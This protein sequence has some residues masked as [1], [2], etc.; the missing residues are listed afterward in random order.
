MIPVD[1]RAS[2]WLAGYPGGGEAFHELLGNTGDVRPHWRPMLEELDRLGAAQVRHRHDF[3]ARQIREDGITYNVYADAKGAERPWQ[4]DLLPHIVPADEWAP[5]AAGIAQRAAV[6]DAMLA[7]L[8]GPQQLLRDGLLPPELV[9]GHDN[10]L[11]PC[12]GLVPPGGRFLHVYAADLARAP[13]GRWWV[14]ADRTQAPS[15]AGYALE[16]RQIVSRAFPELLRAVKVQPLGGFFD[17][18]LATL[19][20]DAPV[21]EGETPLA[22]L[23]TAGRY[24]ETYFEHVFLARHLGVPLVEGQDLTVRGATLYLKTLGGLRRVHAVLRRLDD[25]F[26]D[27]LELRGDSALGVAGLLDVARAGRVLIANALGSGVLDSPGLPGFLPAICERLRGEPLRLPSVATWWCGEA[28]ACEA[29][30]DQ[31]DRLVVKAAFPSQRFEPVFGPDL[32]AA[33]REALRARIRAQPQAYVAQEFV[34]LSQAP[35]W[36]RQGARARIAPRAIGMRVYAVATAQ[37]YTVLPGGLTRVAGRDDSGIVSMQRGGTSKDTWVFAE[38]KHPADAPQQRTLRARDIVRRDD[39][40]PSRLVENLFWVGRYCERIDDTARLLRVV[41][42]RYAD[43]AGHNPAFDAAIDACRVLGLLRGKAPMRQRLLAAVADVDAAG[44][45]AGTLSRLS[46]S[47][48]Q[49]RGRLSQENWRTLA[50]VQRECAELSPDTLDLGDAVALL[51]SLLVGTSAL[52][53][54]AHEDMTRDD[55]W[56]F[57][58][59]ARRLERVQF[60]GD[61]VARVLRH[62]AGTEQATLDWLLELAD[63]TITYRGRYLAAPQLIPVLDLVLCD[64]ANPHSLAFQSSALLQDVAALPDGAAHLPARDVLATQD[65]RLRGCD[66][67][68]LEDALFGDAGRDAALL[69]VAQLAASTADASRALSDALTLRYFAH[70]DLGRQTVSA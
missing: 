60:L 55:G 63:S 1:V 45:I 20:R 39:F 49:V 26:C 28:P 46:W 29:A 56:R 64:P 40:L 58:M 50:E 57:L 44:S 66:L 48:A 51:D 23:L 10:F 43:S 32:D 54:F 38:A 13:D 11:W 2:Q 14:V 17:A 15:G 24:N 35:V 59:I 12:T 21:A 7:D 34:Q 8:Y 4:L 3:V 19:H 62:R 68:A 31:L 30:L 42:G 18:L 37:G 5:L 33:G 52:S 36:Q 65:A 25:D 70:V 27:P 53:G 6:L 9:F 16:N 47:A 69:G 41:L 67:S 61:V 22:V